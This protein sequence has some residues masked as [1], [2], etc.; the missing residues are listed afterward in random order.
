MALQ[1][2]TRDN[3]AKAT[4]LPLYIRILFPSLKSLS[5]SGEVFVDKH[6]LVGITPS[7]IGALSFSA[8]SFPFYFLPILSYHPV[9]GDP[10][11]QHL[12]LCA[13]AKPDLSPLSEC[14]RL[15]SLK[16]HCLD[17]LAEASSYPGLPVVLAACPLEVLVL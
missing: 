5:L 1:A 17:P 3:P 11:L 2:T 7:R 12:A 10:N 9:L 16:L 8:Q 15:K 13:V 4:G 6:F 14:K